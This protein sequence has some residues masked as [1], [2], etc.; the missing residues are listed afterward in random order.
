[1]DQPYGGQF[2]SMLQLLVWCLVFQGYIGSTCSLHKDQGVEAMSV[3]HMDVRHR[4]PFALKT[5]EPLFETSPYELPQM[6]C[7]NQFR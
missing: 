4:D 7:P 5:G 6:N 1:M 2:A 3:A